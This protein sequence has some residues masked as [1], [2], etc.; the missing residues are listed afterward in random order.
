MNYERQLYTREFTAAVLSGSFISFGGFLVFNGIPVGLALGTVGIL[1]GMAGA[2][3]VY[4]N[5]KK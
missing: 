1:I 5:R 4:R 3:S 2:N